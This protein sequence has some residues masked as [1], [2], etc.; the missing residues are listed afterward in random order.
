[1][2]R[3]LENEEMCAWG[4]G[5]GVCCSQMLA[6]EMEVRRAGAWSRWVGFV[7][8]WRTEGVGGRVGADQRAMQAKEAS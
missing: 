2:G 6:E 1:V 3:R 4:P 8:E 7:H 5:G